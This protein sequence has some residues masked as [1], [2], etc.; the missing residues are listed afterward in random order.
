L[1]L[2]FWCPSVFWL[3]LNSVSRKVL[4]KDGNKWGKACA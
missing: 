2:K 1:T 3:T 4:S